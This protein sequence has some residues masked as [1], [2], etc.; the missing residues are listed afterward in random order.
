VTTPADTKRNVFLLILCQGLLFVNNTT[1]VAVNGLVGYSER[2]SSSSP[3]QIAHMPRSM[4][5]PI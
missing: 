1:M 5:P 2:H 3:Y 4:R